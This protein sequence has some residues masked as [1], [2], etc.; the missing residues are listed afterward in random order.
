MTPAFQQ[1]FLCAMFALVD[2][3]LLLTMR[4][5]SSPLRIRDRFCFAG[6]LLVVAAIRLFDNLDGLHSYLYMAALYALYTYLIHLLN[7]WSWRCALQRAIGFFL[8]T[9]CSILALSYC[10]QKWMG[11]DVFRAF[12]SW[13]QFVSMF[14]L[15]GFQ[16][17]CLRLLRRCLPDTVLADNN[18]LLI[19]ALSVVPYLFVCQITLWIPVD[20]ARLSFAVVVVLVASC[21]L[22]LCLM[23]NLERRIAS[24]NE[25]RQME[26]RTHLLQI[27]A[28]QFLIK[29]NSIDALRRNYHDMK[30]L[31]LHLEASPS[32]DNLHAHISRI[33]RDIH[34]FESVVET[35]NEVIDILLS[36][37]I[38]RCQERDIPCVTIL[39]GRLLSFISVADL[40]CI[41]GNAMDN[42][43]EGCMTVADPQNRYIHVRT[44][45]NAQLLVLNF[46]NSCRGTAQKRGDTFVTSKADA[47]HHGFGLR[48]IQ[49]AAARHG[50]TMSCQTDGQSFTLTLL[51]PFTPSNAPIA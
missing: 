13:Q 14:F 41:F 43:M 5:V 24:E 45:V 29:K 35:G 19:S 8:V 1:F 12:P 25:R 26:A 21:L 10:S 48:N 31:L 15:F 7:Q 42:A 49:D 40:V 38:L 17:G 9:E 16:Y 44:S 39:D 28:Q 23:V 2:G 3:A 32:A 34:P 36:E 47:Q 11:Y 18:S 37:K 50:G 33:L 22:A 20:R 27:N 6:G 51:F 4:A 46:R 30:N